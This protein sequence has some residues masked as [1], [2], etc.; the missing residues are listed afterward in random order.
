MVVAARSGRELLGSVWVEC[1]APLDG[2]AL[3]ALI[4]GARTVALHLLRSRASA[5]LERQVESELV[6]RLLEGAADAT[7]ARPLARA[8]DVTLTLADD[9]FGA[10]LLTGTANSASRANGTHHV[11]GAG[12]VAAGDVAR[13]I[14]RTQDLPGGTRA[15]GRAI[16]ETGPFGTAAAVA[17]ALVAAASVGRRG[18][19]GD[20]ATRARAA[21]GPGARIGRIHR[22][23]TAAA[24]HHHGRRGDVRAATA[25]TADGAAV[26]N[27]Q[28]RNDAGL[29]PSAALA[30]ARRTQGNELHLLVEQGAVARFTRHQQKRCAKQ[31]SNPGQQA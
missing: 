28:H 6:I 27:A 25:G 3:T 5:D 23:R 12:P 9:F 15:S 20:G 17:H 24:P 19:A 26:R 14:G 30:E 2:A 1:G 29:S 4:D 13:T 11:V 21:H 16:E 18:R 22:A 8:L 10:R 7:T 31:P